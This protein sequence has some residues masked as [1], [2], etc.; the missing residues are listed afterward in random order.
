MSYDFSAVVDNF[1]LFVC[2][3]L[4]EQSAKNLVFADTNVEEN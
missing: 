2:S 4:S 3:Y 1:L